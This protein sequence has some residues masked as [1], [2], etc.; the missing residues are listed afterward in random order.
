MKY[1]LCSGAMHGTHDLRLGRECVQITLKHR[2]EY[3]FFPAKEVCGN[4][5]MMHIEV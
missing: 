1:A 4:N 3:L 2:K 5:I